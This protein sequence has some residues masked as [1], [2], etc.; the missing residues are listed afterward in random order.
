MLKFFG[1]LFGGIFTSFFL[2]PFTFIGLPGNTKMYLAAVGLVIGIFYFVKRGKSREGIPTN[3]LLLFLSA[4]LVSLTALFSITY[5]Q[6]ED[7]TYVTYVISAAVWLSAAFAVCCFIRAVH[8]RIDVPLVCNY[9]I[10][11]CAFQC[12]SAMVIDFV[13]AVKSFVNTYVEQGQVTL[14]DLDRLYG[15]GAALDVAGSR[16]ACVLVL[17]TFLLHYKGNNVRIGTIW[18]YL[19]SYVIIAVI[20]NMIAR[21]TS[22]GL[23]I[24]AVAILLS[25]VF[26][27]QDTVGS[28]IVIPLV[29]VLF[30][31]TFSGLLL[32]SNPRFE[33]LLRF[34]F[35]GVFNY[36]EAGEYEISST[37]KLKTMIV[38]PEELKTWIIGDGYF[39]SSRYDPNYLG[40]ATE[41]GFYMGTDI[42]YLRFIFYFGIVG[43]LAISAVIIYTAVACS[44]RLPAYWFLFLLLALVGFV[45]WLKVSTDVFL[46]LALFFCVADMQPEE[47]FS[48]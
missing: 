2:F 13:P 20:G 47:E 43:L 32:Y 42:G 9:L 33:E 6:T 44:K 16:F 26:R 4:S 39:L 1:I 8:G 38:F 5:N 3:L 35:E 30:V 40:D 22:V 21:T 24:S 11:V 36:F 19:V 45:V 7:T 37:E 12:V 41:Q 29:A 14:E 27:S 10:T 28:R 48:V 31:G 46:V 23:L 17:I 34:G 15:I 25:F 18:F